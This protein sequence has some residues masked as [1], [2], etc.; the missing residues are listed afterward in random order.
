MLRFPLFM[1]IIAL[2]IFIVLLETFGT[3]WRPF[4]APFN[5]KWRWRP[6]CGVTPSVATK[7]SKFAEAFVEKR[8][9]G[10]QNSTAST[11]FEKA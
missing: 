2:V 4:G 5:D 6:N 3:P 7:T 8:N 9:G 11:I 10:L 1:F